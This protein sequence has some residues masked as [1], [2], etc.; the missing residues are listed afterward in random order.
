MVLLRTCPGSPSPLQIPTLHR[1]YCELRWHATSHISK[2]VSGL[3]V[4]ST[5]PHFPTY[6]IYSHCQPF[7]YHQPFK[8]MP[9][10]PFH[11][12]KFTVTSTCPHFPTYII[13]SHCQ[14]FPDHQP[15][16]DMP[17]SPFHL[18][19]FKLATSHFRP[20]IVGLTVRSTCPREEITLQNKALID[21]YLGTCERT[22]WQKKYLRQIFFSFLPPPLHPILIVFVLSRLE[23]VSF[24]LVGI[25]RQKI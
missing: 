9:R 15:F 13:Y 25:I 22:P 4:T 2:L 1:S 24:F 5:C 7:P 11:L 18:S 16:K 21:I 17:R 23:Y 3:T 19:R 12:S 10:S 6:G 14:P 8:D 20:I